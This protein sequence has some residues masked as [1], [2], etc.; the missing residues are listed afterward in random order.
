MYLR[1]CGHDKSAPTAADG[2][3][4][5]QRTHCETPYFDHVYTKKT[6]KTF[7]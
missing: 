2:L 3:P 4:I 1:I 5:I 6:P 7:G